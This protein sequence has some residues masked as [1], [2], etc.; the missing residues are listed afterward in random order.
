MRVLR[1]A[2][3]VLLSLFNIIRL[4]ILTNAIKRAEKRNDNEQIENEV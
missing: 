3:A 1:I 4:F 2:V